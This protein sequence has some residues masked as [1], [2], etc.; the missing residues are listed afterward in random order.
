MGREIANLR[1]ENGRPYTVANRLHGQIIEFSRVV[2]TKGFDP[3]PIIST[4]MYLFLE[5][6]VFPILESQ[7]RPYQYS[8]EVLKDLRAHIDEGE[9]QT[10][11]AE[12]QA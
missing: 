9:Y 3:K 4:E 1:N 5:T 12:Q 6:Q 10:R 2:L 8:K 11:K 7:N